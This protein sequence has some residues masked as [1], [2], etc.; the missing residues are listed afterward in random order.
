[1]V[2]QPYTRHLHAADL[3]PKMEAVTKMQAAGKTA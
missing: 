3:R 2:D 1:M